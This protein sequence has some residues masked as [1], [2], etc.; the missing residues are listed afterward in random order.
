MSVESRVVEALARA[1]T[2]ID[3][4]KETV[5]ILLEDQKKDH[6]EITRIGT[7]Q[8]DVDE[9]FERAFS[10]LKDRKDAESDAERKYIVLREQHAQLRKEFDEAKQEKRD[11]VLHKRLTGKEIAVGVVLC[12]LNTVIG[13]MIT[14]WLANVFGK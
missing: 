13:G 7:R 12:V 1:T 9:K 8:G 2:A 14:L 3:Q 11:E 10:A 4:V 6:D 5:A